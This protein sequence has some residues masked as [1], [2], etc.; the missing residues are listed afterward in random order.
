MAV[1]RICSDIDGTLI[2]YGKD[3][4]S[5]EIL[6]RI[7]LLEEKGI[8]FC[9]SSGRQYSSLARLFHKVKDR[10]VFIC[11]NGSVIF[12]ND[13]CI[14]EKPRPR[15]LARDIAFDF[16]NR[17]DEEGEVLLSGQNRG[18]LMERG[19]GRLDRRRHIGNLHKVIH[20]FDEI[21][22]DITKVSLYLPKGVGPYKDRFLE[23]WKE[24]NCD[25][26]GLY[27]IDTTLANKGSGVKALCNRF[28]IDPK[29]V[30]AFGDNYNDVS[31]LDFVGHPF[32]RA[33]SV[34]ELKDRYP[35]HASS[36]EEVIRR[37]L[38]E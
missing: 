5:D 26:A 1:K 34:D 4:L 37:I 36:P 6:E 28:R 8:L 32:I 11:E 35:N 12:R 27:W 3:Y 31:R 17:C 29:D 30:V 16:Y 2:P 18:Y 10:C 19:L 23:K 38:A 22:E 20:D 9:P 24:A 13:A 7:P 21:K 14:Y 33:D 25:V 15:K